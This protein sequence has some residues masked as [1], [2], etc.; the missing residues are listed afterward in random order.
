ML[1]KLY[2]EDFFEKVGRPWTVIEPKIFTIICTH[3]EF[4]SFFLETDPI[5]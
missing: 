1:D 4:A 3:Y 2:S 5:C